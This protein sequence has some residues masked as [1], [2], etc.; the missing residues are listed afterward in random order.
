VFERIFFM[1]FIIGNWLVFATNLSA[2][3]SNKEINNTVNVL[4]E[5]KF[6][7]NNVQILSNSLL[8]FFF[9]LTSFFLWITIII[10]VISSYSLCKI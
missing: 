5:S 7:N 6:S 1:N 3:F 2:S 4:L 10:I 9:F 8:I